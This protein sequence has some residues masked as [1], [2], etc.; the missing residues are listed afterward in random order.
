[1]LFR[2]RGDCFDPAT[3]LDTDIVIVG[4][5]MGGASFAA[6]L[7]GSGIKTIMLEAGDFVPDAPDNRAPRTVYQEMR[8]HSKTPWIDKHG[9][10]FIPG[11]YEWVGGNTKFYGAVLYRF[12]EADFTEKQL[13]EGTRPAWPFGYAELQPWYEK[14][15]LLMK[16]RGQEGIDP[17][18]P[19]GPYGYRFPPVPDEPAIAALRRRLEKAGVRTAPLPLGVNI[20]AWMAD[21]QGPWDGYPDATCRGK[22]DAESC[23]LPVAAENPAFKLVTKARVTRLILGPDG[24]TLSGVE[25]T[26][27]EQTHTLRAKIVVLAAGAVSSAALLLKSGLANSSDQVGRNFMNHIFSVIIAVDPR[28]RNTSHYQKTISINDFYFDDN[29]TGKPLGNIQLLGRIFG[30]T[31]RHDVKRV[32]LFM[33]NWISAHAA[34]FFLQTEDVPRPENRV[35]VTPEGLTRLEWHRPHIPTHRAMVAR[36]KKMLRAAGFP[37]LLHR[38]MDETI[39]YHQCGTVRMGLDAKTS[40]IRPD[41]VT[42]D[43]PNLM[44]VDASC[45]VSSAGVNPALTVSAIALRAADHAKRLLPTL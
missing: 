14:A 16:V 18:E 17:T 41:N 12:R 30:D 35:T 6:G 9:R 23:L 2:D 22:M 42:W 15:E 25:F 38:L 29:D 20:D 45:F 43:H 1:M 24:K 31:L 44:V 33:L 11:T 34:D 26:H 3:D 37:I 36:A 28:F 40:V 13:E 27:G 19:P 10:P 39:P 7:A 21:Q 32:P 5:G 8:F 4:S